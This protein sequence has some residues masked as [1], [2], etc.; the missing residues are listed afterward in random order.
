MT[1]NKFIKLRNW[2]ENNLSNKVKKTTG[3]DLFDW[4]NIILLAAGLLA[5]EYLMYIKFID[6]ASFLTSFILWFTAFVLIR[7]TKE[8]YWLKVLAQEQT[9]HLKIEHKTNLR[10]YLRLQKK[11]GENKLQLVNEGKGVAVNL[12][13][14]YRK[15][16]QAVQLP[17]ITAMAA[18]PGSVTEG[19]TPARLG[20]DFDSD[21]DCL[22]E[23]KYND[24]EELNYRAVFKRNS[25][26]NDKFEIVEQKEI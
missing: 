8:T 15:G 6:P 11:T 20:I 10:P 13:S 2:L 1:K 24:V 7:Y 16:E 25:D 14:T 22:I 3:N 9:D 18:A 5:L 4:T 17:G 12:R 21:D 23:I 26:Y 19:L